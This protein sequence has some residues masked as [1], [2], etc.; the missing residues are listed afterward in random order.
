MIFRIHTLDHALHHTLAVDEK[1]LAEGTHVGAS[2]ELL[3]GPDTELLLQRGVC[4][5]DEPEGQ[6]LLFDESAVRASAVFADADHVVAG[7]LQIGI[8][9]AQ[10]TGLGCASAG[11]VLG[12]EVQS[13]ATTAIIAHAHFLSVLIRPEQVGHAIAYLY[14]HKTT[15]D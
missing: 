4:I 10:A 2:V 6:A 7:R 13:N 15:G 5:G 9:V 14:S 12:V 11:V 8:A 3:L 1:R